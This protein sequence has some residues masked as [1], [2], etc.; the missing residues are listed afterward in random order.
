MR[1][2][3]I[4]ID[5][6]GVFHRNSNS[7]YF[8]Y[9]GYV[10]ND[11][12][13]LDN[14]KRKYRTLVKEIKKETGLEGELKSYG[15]D[16]NLR[17]ALFNVMRANHSLSVCT[18]LNKIHDNIINQKRSIQRFKDYALKRAIKEKIRQLIDQAIIDPYEELTINIYVDE[19]TTA[20]NGLYL[21]KD[22]VL[23]ELKYGIM[24][25]DY[26]KF[27][28][29]IIHGKLTV[30]VMYCESSCNYMIQ[31][32]DILANRYYASFCQH[33]PQLRKKNNH[34]GLILP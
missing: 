25:F 22:S 13:T 1:E 33:K 4:F 8:V 3:Y 31:A 12:T 19:Q 9:A 21:L 2:I 14:E 20:S 29:P 6:S 32:S 26:G 11:R 18:N 27:H 10:F 24:N 5:D 7:E 23:E 15:L 28:E 16:F 17:R 34:Y 30:K